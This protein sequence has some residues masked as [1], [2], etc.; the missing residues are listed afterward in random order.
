MNRRIFLIGGSIAAVIVIALGGLYVL[1]GRNGGS[2]GFFARVASGYQAI[3]SGNVKISELQ[4]GGEFSFQR[5][6]IDTTKPQAEACLAFTK[7]LDVSGKTHY[8]DYLAID[9]KTRIVVRPVDQ[10][11]CISGL[12]FNQT[13]NVTLKAGLPAQGGVKLAEAETV[14]VE[15]RDKPALVRFGGGIILPRDNAEGVPVTTVNIDKLKIMVVR[16]GDRLLS[17]IESG[18]VDQT[19]LYSYDQKQLTD[20]QGAV[21]FKG[22]MDVGNVKNESVVTQIPIRD[23]LKNKPPGAYVL[24]ARDAAKAKDDSDTSYDD[25]ERAAQWV[26]ASDIGLTTF[27]GADGLSVFSRSYATAKP[28]SNVRLTLVARDNNVLATVTTDSDGRAD[29]DPGLFKAT[30]GEEPVVVMAY[31]ANGDFSFLDLRRPAFD[32]TDRGV[33]GR[34]SPGPVD[35]FLYTERGVYRPGET[36]EAVATMRDKVGAVVN[37]P[38]TLIATRPDGV[39]FSRTTVASAATMAGSTAWSLALKKT[40]PHG[41]W[42]I[43]A[44]IDPKGDAIGRVE[45][46]VADFV[47]QRLKVTLAPQ[48]TV[49][50]PNMDL[51]IRAESRFLYGA[52]AAGLSGEGEARITSDPDPYPQFSTYH[53][54]RMDDS[55]SDVTVTL[56]V[57]NTDDAGV[58]TATATIGD[59]TDTTLPLKVIAKVSIHEPGGRTTDKTAEIPLRTRDVA[60]GI[61]AKFQDSSVSENAPASFEVIAVD[62]SGK[63]IALQHLNYTWVKEVTNYQWFQDQQ[64][65]WKYE[66]T[67]R[68]RLVTSGITDIGTGAPQLLTGAFPWGTYRLTISDPKS[69]AAS[70]YRFYSGWAASA[71]GDRPDRIPVAADKPSYKPGD[72]AHISIKPAA[73]GQALVVVAGDRVYSSKLID[74]PAGGTTIDVPISS[75][76]GA[77]AY[78]LVT[79]YRALNDAT[80]REPVRSIGVAWLGV[81]NSERTLTPLIG[82]PAKITPRQKITIP[83][84]VK[85]LDSGENAYITLAAVDEGILQLTDYKS[86]DPNGFYFGKRRLGVGM[87]DDYGR[88]IKAEKGPVGSLREGGDNLGGRPLAVVPTRTVALF[89]GIVKVGSGGM[90][91]IPLAIPDFNGELRLMAVAMS[92]KKIGHAERPLTVR[93][94][95]V[96]ELILPRFLAPGDKAASS[97]DLNNVEGANG[98]YTATITTSGPLGF[99]DGS[100]H[101]ESRNLARGQRALVPFVLDGRDLGIAN[102]ALVL[103]GPNGYKVN[104]SWQIEVR[105]PQLDVVRDSIEPLGPHQS[106]VANHTLVADVVPQTLVAALNVSATHGYG[107]V[108]GLLRWLNKYPYGCVEQTTSAAMPLLYFN[109]LAAMAAITKDQAL[110]QRLQDSVDNV[111]DMQNY[112][113]NFGMWGPGTDADPW[114]SVFAIDFL[115]QAKQKGY[116]VPNDALKRGAQ[117]LRQQSTSDSNDDNVRAYAFYVLAR[118]GQVNLSDLRYFSDTRGG[119]WN[120]AIAAALTGA[121]AAEAGDRSRATYAFGRARDLLMAANPVTYSSE[122]YGS[123]VR[124]LAGTTALAIEGGDVE[125]IP[126][127]MKR[128]ATVNMGLNATT[129]QEKAWMLRAA[130]QLTH[131][132]TPLRVLVNGKPAQPKDGAVRLVPTYGALNAGITL[133][134]AGDA[135]VW[136]ETSVQGTPSQPQPADASGLSIKKTVWTLSGQPADLSSL[137]Q[138]DRVMIVLEG[139]MET[140]YLHHMA[141]LDLLPAGLEIEMPVAGDDAKAYPWL[142]KLSDVNREDA[143][144]DRFVA[145]FDIGSEYRDKP[146]PKKPLPPPPS[147]RI[148]YIARAVT[149]GT[150]VMPAGVVEDMYS[151][152]VHARTAMGTM[153]VK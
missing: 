107:D 98:S 138:N 40:A 32:L 116:V 62:G 60:I 35:A 67:T 127:L 74:A 7:N 91:Q 45:F 41:R 84:V 148:A 121:A 21:V 30:G 87:H 12:S 137:K 61:S 18:V 38:L 44:Y 53:F 20:S 117:W 119:D 56:N 5:L 126:P 81:D 68:D 79:D 106:F 129:T 54:G 69:K 15:L 124:D 108:P 37:A 125:I 14:P 50:H 150:F 70:S 101:S 120:T 25:Q 8:E 9:P 47:P 85:G 24:I 115:V 114:I 105:A 76:W 22:T 112:A 147:Y 49:L 153:T 64:G 136:R 151:P 57:P 134:N 92:D 133:T 97:L 95:V 99:D 3:T 135:G 75:E 11:L 86:P 71:A 130:Y 132:K 90:A 29:F 88:L 103:S 149:Q 52:P 66:S 111:L 48:E 139:Q 51:H 82:G 34:P 100:T 77:G 16:V 94:P 152:S 6:D 42:Q 83:V 23:I 59:V 102:I 144:D 39:E 118:M 2:G 109:D 143:H 140:P 146:D 104:R 128:A 58:T 72:T 89:S 131:Q 63:R 17:Q 19:S 36:V 113:G 31:G 28:L 46:N 65:Q 10:R 123:Y 55:F 26:I 80:G 33:G 141:A 78:V 96:A 43:A 145:A 93:D 1:G 27:Q 142:D 13:Y 73:D 110:P 122:D 4:Q